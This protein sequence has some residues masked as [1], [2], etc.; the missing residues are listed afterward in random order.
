MDVREDGIKTGWMLERMELRQ[1]GCNRMDVREDGIKTGYCASN[2]E[3]GGLM[4][5]QRMWNRRMQ[6]NKI[7]NML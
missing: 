2:S 4:L 5:D 3:N 6:Q 1:D 7:I